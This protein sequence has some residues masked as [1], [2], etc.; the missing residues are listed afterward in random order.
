MTRHT[1]MIGPGLVGFIMLIS[2]TGAGLLIYF[3]H[4]DPSFAVEANYYDRAVHWDEAAAQER[5]NAEL[6]WVVEVEIAPGGGDEPGSLD[7]ALADSRGGAIDGAR[8]SVEAFHNARASDRTM[9][10]LEPA[11]P[12]RYSA[13]LEIGRAGLWEFRVTAT[14]GDEVFTA[15]VQRM[16]PELVP[17]RGSLP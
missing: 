9:L 5:R 16:I 8:V 12:G 13:P 14:R 15:V 6:A 11:E 1:W 2:L 4:S 10:A 7:L 17:E 3:A